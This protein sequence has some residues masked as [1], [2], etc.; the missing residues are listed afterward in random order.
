MN[1]ERG[2]EFGFAPADEAPIPYLRRIADYYMR[3]GYGVPYEWAHYSDVPF[4]PLRKPLQESSV[5]IVTTAAP[6][7]P[8]KG[9]QGPGAPY[10]AAAK[11]YT[12]YS[13]DTSVDHDLRIAH[14]AIDRQHTTAE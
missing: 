6:Y 5:A 14:V 13:G 10:N 4:R 2:R 11:F 1:G 9:D 12:V 8:G 7:Q 3:L